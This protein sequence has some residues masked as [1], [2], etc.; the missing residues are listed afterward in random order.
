MQQA[1]RIL[2]IFMHAFV[3][4]D[5]DTYMH[6]FLQMSKL[7]REHKELEGKLI[8]RESEMVKLQEAHNSLRTASEN[9]KV[10]AADKVGSMC[11]N[12]CSDCVICCIE[13]HGLLRS[14]FQVLVCAGLEY[15]L[16]IQSFHANTCMYI[17]MCVY[18]YMYIYIYITRILYV[19]P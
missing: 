1:A 18:I 15:L 11:P 14:R 6:T 12:S 4:P 17:S 8:S 3:Y 9:L 5:I 19:S 16:G 10:M 13:T 2:N 7:L